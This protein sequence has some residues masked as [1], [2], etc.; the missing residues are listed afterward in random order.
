M[1][2][3][4][5]CY[6]L[7]L[8][9]FLITVNQVLD[10]GYNQN[11]Y[12][13]ALSRL[14]QRTPAICRFTDRLISACLLDKT[15]ELPYKSFQEFTQKGLIPTLALPKYNRNQPTKYH[16]FRDALESEAIH[17]LIDQLIEEGSLLGYEVT[18]LEGDAR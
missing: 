3:R 18:I 13:T 15:N 11:K 16:M 5:L 4:A 17:G 9:C 2:V 12:D 8:S 1:Y 10:G 6:T 7:Y 14:D